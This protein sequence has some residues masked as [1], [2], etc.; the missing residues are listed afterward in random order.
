MVLILKYLLLLYNKYCYL[1]KLLFKVE[2]VYFY[3]V[4]ILELGYIRNVWWNCNFMKF[5]VYLGI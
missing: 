1:R 2:L 3:Y 5:I 4:F